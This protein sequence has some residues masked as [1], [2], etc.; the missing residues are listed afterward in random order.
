MQNFI[1]AYS[2]I[3]LRYLL[4]GLWIT[5]EVSVISIFFSFI[6]GTLLGIARYVKV[7]YFSAIVGF[8][9]DLIRNLPLLLILFFTYFALPDI[10]IRLDVVTSSIVAMTIFESAMLAEIV[11]SGINAVSIGQMEASRS[12]G[13]SYYQTMRYIIMPQAFKKMIPPIVSQFISLVK[14][15]SLATIILLPELTYHSQIIY[16]QNINYMIPM[17]VA[18]AVMYF[19]VNFALSMASRMLEKRLAS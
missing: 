4:E 14:D 2:W 15:T 19:I 8:I 3:N 17:F 9:I 11:R 5:I 16:G 13:M 12:N 7:K 18:L 10:G 6:I 1:D